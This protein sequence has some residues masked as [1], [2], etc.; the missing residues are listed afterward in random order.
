M[1]HL[2]DSQVEDRR[3]VLMY[4]TSLHVPYSDAAGGGGLPHL[5]IDQF[6][7]LAVSN[8]PHPWLD[9]RT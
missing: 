4:R 8:E 7:D 6:I 3:V 2:L 1:W 9:F 5:E